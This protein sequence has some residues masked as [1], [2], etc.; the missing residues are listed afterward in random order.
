[1]VRPTGPIIYSDSIKLLLKYNV[2]PISRCIKQ[3]G[4]IRFILPTLY[5]GWQPVRFGNQ[6]LLFRIDYNYI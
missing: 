4:L 6:K 2:G 3:I 1:M 5:Y